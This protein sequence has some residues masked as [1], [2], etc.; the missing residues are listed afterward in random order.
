MKKLNSLSIFFPFYNDEGTVISQIENAYRI[1]SAV[2]DEL[3]VI[4]IHGGSSKDKTFEKIQE[5]KKSAGPNFKIT[6]SVSKA[7]VLTDIKEIYQTGPQGFQHL[8][9][10]KFI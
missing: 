10:E 9:F 1:G 5:A 2:S 6:K 3:E 8:I 7:T 4:A